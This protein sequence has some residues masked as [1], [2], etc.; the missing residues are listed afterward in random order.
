MHS[1]LCGCVPRNFPMAQVFCFLATNK[2]KKNNYWGCISFQIPFVQTGLFGNKTQFYD[3]LGNLRDVVP[4][5]DPKHFP[6]F[7]FGK[8]K[9]LAHFLYTADVTTVTAPVP[10]LLEDLSCAPCARCS[11]SMYACHPK[12]TEQRSGNQKL[13]HALHWCDYCHLH[14]IKCFLLQAALVPKCKATDS[15]WHS[16]HYCGKR[17]MPFGTSMLLTHARSSVG[18]FFFFFF[19]VSVDQPG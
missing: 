7:F 17:P 13:Q 16:W 1:Y 11:P 15:L 8:G 6:F 10:A 9:E 2:K 18:F 3:F 19:V 12:C 5:A 4:K 14:L